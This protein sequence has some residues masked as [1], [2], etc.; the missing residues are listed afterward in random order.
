M[1][2]LPSLDGLFFKKKLNPLFSENYSVIAS[3]GQPTGSWDNIHQTYRSYVTEPANPSTVLNRFV[4]GGC[5]E[6]VHSHWRWGKQFGQP[7][8]NGNLYFPAGSDQDF[9]IGIVRY[10]AG[11]EHPSNFLDLISFTN[12]E[13]IRSRLDV[14][15]PVTDNYKGSV[16]EETVSWMLATGHKSTDEFFSHYSF[17][18]TDEP[19]V[20][21]PIQRD[22][23]PL[24]GKNY[25]E[26]AS[27]TGVDAPIS[28]T[29]GH[30]LQDGTTA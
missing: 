5:P 16:P 12:P 29:Y 28:I 23:V 4:A 3:N 1:G 25:T 13:P 20:T 30:L 27:L 17:F 19:N 9:A 7:F 18:N 22:S 24:S 15:L 14:L 8:N 11:E 6:C 26:E 21:R 2:C 10:H